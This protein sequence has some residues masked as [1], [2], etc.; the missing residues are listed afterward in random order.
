MLR[1]AIW[2]FIISLVVLFIF[3]PSY[4]RMQDL[5]QKNAD[6][7]KQIEALKRDNAKLLEEN[8]L[9]EEDPEYLEK[10]GREKMGLIREGEVV[11]K[12]TPITEEE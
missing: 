5:Q 6:Y 4:T 10:V 8:R 7:E 2:L 3:L 1:N 9:L 12:I 11:Y